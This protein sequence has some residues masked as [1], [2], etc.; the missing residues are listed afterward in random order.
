MC[1]FRS[2]LD[3][4]PCGHLFKNEQNVFVYCCSK[5]NQEFAI[6]SELEEHILAHDIKNEIDSVGKNNE[7]DVSLNIQYSLRSLSIPITRLST[8]LLK[9]EPITH[10]TEAQET[11][12]LDIYKSENESLLDIDCINLDKSPS[13]DEIQSDKPLTVTVSKPGPKSKTK[14]TLKPQK[15]RLKSMKKREKSF[16]CDICKAKFSSY[17]F[18]KRHLLDGHKNKNDWCRIKPKRKKKDPVP[19]K[20]CGKM[21]VAINLHMRTFHSDDRPFKCNKCGLTYKYKS[22]LESHERLHTGNRLIEIEISFKFYFL[23]QKLRFN[24]SLGDRPW[25]CEW[26]SR[27]FKRYLI[28]SLL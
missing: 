11:D 15:K 10:D 5:C 18:V 24:F 21:L 7:T 3:R 6:S 4:I 12:I 17:G 27:A 20:I 22:N 19:C 23:L 2:P 26:C 16:E 8:D 14:T 1:K 25:L 9:N 13:S 28:L